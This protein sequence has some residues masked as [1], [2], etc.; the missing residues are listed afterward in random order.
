MCSVTLV[1]TR[2]YLLA[3]IAAVKKRDIVHLFFKLHLCV[4]MWRRGTLVESREQQE[5]ILS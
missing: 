3:L 1:I 5:L 2:I 4:Y